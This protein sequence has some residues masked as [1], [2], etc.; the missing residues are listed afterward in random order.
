VSIVAN[1]VLAFNNINM[2][3]IKDDGALERLKDF[4][5]EQMERT[6][7]RDMM[8]AEAQRAAIEEL[9]PTKA[10]AAWGAAQFAPGA[11]SLDLSGGM[12]IPPPEGLKLQD[13][14]AYMLEGEKMLS[15]AENWERGGWGYLE[16]IAQGLGSLGDATYAA[17]PLVG[18]TLGSV[19]K[20]P[21]VARNIAKAALSARQVGK[22]AKTNV[23]VVSDIDRGIGALPR[24]GA[25][26][27]AGSVPNRL[28]YTP[29]MGEIGKDPL[30]KHM[31]EI[32]TRFADQLNSDVDGAIEQYKNL[33][34]S[35]GGRI[36]SVDIARELSP[37]YVADRSL[38]AA[39]HEPSSAFIKEHY[40]RMLKSEVP[41]DK[42][43][44]VL[45]TAGGT[46]AGKSTALADALL[47]K[48]VKSHLV[49]DGN[50]A[51]YS[52]SKGKIQQA[53]D[54]G[55]DVTI[56][57][58]HR[59]PIEA[60]TG[61]ALPR[62]TKQGRTVPIDAHASTHVRSIETVKDLAKHYD[63][64]PNVDIRVIDNT[65]GKGNALDAGNDLSG[66]PEY[67]Y[68]ELLQE[69]TDEL[70]KALKE[71]KISQKVYDGFIGS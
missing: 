32:E 49:Y 60:L 56:A 27:T 50:L 58:V 1:I 62:A 71:G 47:D 43:N 70:N 21:G 51:G 61:G 69:A 14:P 18:A 15:A 66:L 28:N 17:G 23:N 48:T 4:F 37:D 12:V 19:F 41:P 13:L 36:I 24:A 9:T 11:A 64:N 39:V 22:G 44:E 68:N 65:R 55:K 40:A 30:P 2:T 8:M 59:H 42:F 63:G 38:S 26:M 54:T 7:E 10:Q 45:F 33:P 31:R 29:Y 20:A 53:L 16:A 3:E 52:S 5:A 6:I 25:T 67:D 46:G 57:Y 34:D 35:D